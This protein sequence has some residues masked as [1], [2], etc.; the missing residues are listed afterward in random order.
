MS[1]QRRHDAKLK[2]GEEYLSPNFPD[3]IDS[4]NYTYDRFLSSG[5]I[6]DDI[7]SE[8]FGYKAISR[9]LETKGEWFW[10]LEYE[11][12]GYSV[13]VAFP[14]CQDQGQENGVKLNQSIAVYADEKV[15]EES[16]E[17]LVKVLENRFLED[18]LEKGRHLYE[19]FE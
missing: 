17:N 10:T 15:R 9:G 16:L 19:R 5:G 8:V 4:L 14:I 7:G 2:R 18:A 13:E 6:L 1:L 12:N 11:L 3:G